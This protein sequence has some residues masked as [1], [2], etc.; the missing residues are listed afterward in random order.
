M[1]S[2]GDID[3]NN[4]Q[5]ELCNRWLKLCFEETI[6]ESTSYTKLKAKDYYSN[7]KFP[8]VDQGGHFISG[9]I[10]DEKLL[11][12]GDLPVIIFGDHTRVIKYIDFKFAAGADGTKIL[13]PISFYNN[14]FYYYYLKSLEIPSLGY[15][16]HFKILKELDFPIPSLSEQ[17]RI[18]KK[19]DSLFS[20]LEI[21]KEKMSRVPKLLKQ[22][23]QAVLTQAVTGKLTE[24]WRDG[25]GL[26]MYYQNTESGKMREIAYSIPKEWVFLSF[27]TVAS[28][29]SNLVKS[30]EYLDFPLIAPNNIEK[31]TGL[32]IDK[33]IV[34]DI[35]PKSAKHY[36]KKRSIIYSKIRP[37]LSKVIIA[38]FDGL[39]S[40]DMYPIVS[41]I[42][43]NYLFYYM[44]SK[45]FL[46]YATTAGERSVLPK[47]NQKELSIIPVSVPSI[48]EQQEIVKRVESLFKKADAIEEAYKSLE[49]Q[50][51]QLP[52]AILTKAFSGELVE[53]LPTDGDAKDLLKEIIK[54]K[55]ELSKKKKPVK[56]AK[57]V[58]KKLTNS[59]ANLEAEYPLYSIL[60]NIID[61]CGEEKLFT[62]SKMP[63]HK[64]LFQLDIELEKKV[65]IYKNDNILIVNPKYN[66]N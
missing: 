8:V 61:G 49:Y 15:S 43:T 60:T 10:D 50:F 5:V 6:G 47:I 57:S 51:D 24:D 27:S 55:E 53:Q 11:Y 63:Q 38:D 14:R 22:F 19:L 29:E 36:F 17:D 16:R 25:R 30:Q 40:A 39:C 48:E 12:K 45:E 59:A 31:E 52:Q 9:Y 2:R 7:G 54:L 62:L 20:E 1:A 23:R 21:V 33:P 46:Y 4:I 64:F 3:K 26:N 28:I 18:V 65:I 58:K 44:L 13:K 32:L 35:N 41:K 42:E 56:K 66:E 37:Y 34:R